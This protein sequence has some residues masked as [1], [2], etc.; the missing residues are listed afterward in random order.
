MGS[1]KIIMHPL[2]KVV[3]EYTLNK[4][5]EQIRSEKLMNISTWKFMSEWLHKNKYCIQHDTK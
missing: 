1:D 4:L 5:V 3:L 2:Y